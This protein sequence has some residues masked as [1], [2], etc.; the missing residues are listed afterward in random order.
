MV[1]EFRIKIFQKS[2]NKFNLKM[3]DRIG[4]C[5]NWAIF[6]SFCIPKQCVHIDRLVIPGVKMGQARW[7]TMASPGLPD[8]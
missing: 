5:L 1:K 6:S 2:V 7:A 8:Q 3:F 4:Y